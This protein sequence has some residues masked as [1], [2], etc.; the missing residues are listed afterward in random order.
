MSNGAL[1]GG[2]T[3]IE[4]RSHRGSPTNLIELRDLCMRFRTQSVLQAIALSIHRGE[5]VCM[6]GESGCGKTVLLKLIIG[7]LRPTTGSVWFDGM[8]VI[9]SGARR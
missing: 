8:D 5:T 4:P 7:L 6:I 3:G 1:E 9:A 2:P